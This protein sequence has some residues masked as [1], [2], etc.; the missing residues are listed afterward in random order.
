MEKVT[1]HVPKLLNAAKAQNTAG[2]VGPA[3]CSQCR[4]HTFVAK[5]RAGA[6]GGVVTIEAAAD[7]NDTDTWASVGTITWA[8][9]NRSHYLSVAGV[10][11][12][13]RA[14]VSTAVDGGG[15]DVDYVGN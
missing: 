5:F 10:H 11:L 7:P 15:V 12:S 1:A 6:T 8:A 3:V 13:L 4:E 9:A 14:R 2:V